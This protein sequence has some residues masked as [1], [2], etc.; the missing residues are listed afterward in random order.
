MILADLVNRCTV[1]TWNLN[2]VNKV[3]EW[4]IEWM[5]DDVVVVFDKTELGL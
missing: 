2:W 3:D 1:Q 5:N 4:M